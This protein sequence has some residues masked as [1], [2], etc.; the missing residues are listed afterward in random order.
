MPNFTPLDYQYLIYLLG[1][2][3]KNDFTSNKKKIKKLTLQYPLKMS[4]CLPNVA[5]RNM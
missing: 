2:R 5:E 4:N 3:L 1:L